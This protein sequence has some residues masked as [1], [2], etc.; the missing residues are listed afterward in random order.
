MRQFDVYPNPDPGR[1]SKRPYVVV[2]QHDHLSDLASVVVVP[3]VRAEGI[4]PIAGLMPGVSVEGELFYVV[5][6]DM[7]ATSRRHLKGAV[8]NLG[9]FRDDLIKAVDR[10]FTGL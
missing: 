10:L 5:L 2:L 3:L 7:A 4:V 8:A 9:Q 6:P 1:S